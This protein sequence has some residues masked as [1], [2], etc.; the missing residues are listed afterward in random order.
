M[1]TVAAN[2]AEADASP[3]SSHVTESASDVLDVLVNS[4]GVGIGATASEH[5]AKYVDLQLGVNVRAIILLYRE[6]IEL[7]R[8]AGS[9][10]GNALGARLTHG[11]PPKAAR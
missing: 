7:L 6:A 3:A 5:E 10:H 1:E 2:L 4:A 8:A 11:A 9:E